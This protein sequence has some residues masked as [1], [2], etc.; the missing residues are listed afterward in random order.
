MGLLIDDS[1][2]RP[3]VP[4]ADL[5]K[6]RLSLSS[7]LRVLRRA[8]LAVNFAA[9]SQLRGTL[10]QPSFSAS[11]LVVIQSSSLNR[12]LRATLVESA[13]LSTSVDSLSCSVMLASSTRVGV[14]AGN[15][16]SVDYLGCLCRIAPF[17][18]DMRLFVIALLF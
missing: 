18:F 8:I 10:L 2:T 4:E 16:A 5:A 11:S 15:E 6:P 14:R 9:I 1:S 7:C 13:R 12:T 3:S 17:I